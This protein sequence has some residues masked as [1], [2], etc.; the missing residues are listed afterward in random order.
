VSDGRCAVD[1][2][3][4]HE[5][6]VFHMQS[7]Q[8]RLR[9]SRHGTSFTCLLSAHWL[10]AL[11]TLTVCAVYLYVCMRCVCDSVSVLKGFDH[12]INHEHHIWA[13]IF[14]FIHLYDTKQCDYTSLELYVHRLVRSTSSLDCLR[15]YRLFVVLLQSLSAVTTDGEWCLTRQD[16]HVAVFR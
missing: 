7:W 4:R 2:R 5:G 16:Q 3:E 8:L 15:T 11:M 6:H 13:Y 12:H 1:G 10:T 9:T 14:F